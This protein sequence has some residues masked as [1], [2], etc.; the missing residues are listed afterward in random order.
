MAEQSGEKKPT[1]KPLKLVYFDLE[2]THFKPPENPEVVQIMSIG[3]I[4]GDKEFV[5][6]MIPTCEVDPTS[7][8]INGM[9]IQDGKLFLNGEE[10]EKAV[11][12]KRGLSM[13]MDFLDD[14]SDNGKEDLCLVSIF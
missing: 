1:A 7:G 10:V 3:A 8:K 14:E 6:Y 13:F 9:K 11:A 4:S 5:Q 12:I 2:T